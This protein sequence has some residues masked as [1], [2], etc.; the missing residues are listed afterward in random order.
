M[1]VRFYG[2]YLTLSSKPNS[3]GNNTIHEREMEN[4]NEFSQISF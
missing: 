2:G 4:K 3:L 1:R